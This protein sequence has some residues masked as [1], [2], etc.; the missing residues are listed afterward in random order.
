MYA[1]V[2]A[3]FFY[4]TNDHMIMINWKTKVL[5]CWSFQYDDRTENCQEEAKVSLRSNLYFLSNPGF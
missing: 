5:Y 4:F 2:W 3:N 1:T